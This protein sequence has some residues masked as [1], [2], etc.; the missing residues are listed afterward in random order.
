MRISKDT[1]LPVFTISDMNRFRSERAYA[2]SVVA[3]LMEYLASADN[4][5]GTGRLYIP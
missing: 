4:L 5:P 2:E 1:S 3:R